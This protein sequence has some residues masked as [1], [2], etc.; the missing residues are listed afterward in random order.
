MDDRPSSSQYFFDGF[1]NWR[2]FGV[3]IAN[4]SVGLVI[5]AVYKYADVVVKT[6]GIAGSVVTLYLLETMG[7]LS[8]KGQQ[9][10][11]QG[12]IA[13]LGASIVFLASYVYILPAPKSVVVAPVLVVS[14]PTAAIDGE[15]RQKEKENDADDGDGDNGEEL[16]LLKSDSE[17]NEE[18][19]TYHQQNNSNNTIVANDNHNVNRFGLAYWSKLEWS[20]LI[21]CIFLGSILTLNKC[22]Q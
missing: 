11:S 7:V 1:N 13:L 20:L 16:K 4:G 15:N 18:K 12:P 2:V 21:C 19:E 10:T 8:A 14:P 3:V 5:T 6:F 22:N 9:R 17:K